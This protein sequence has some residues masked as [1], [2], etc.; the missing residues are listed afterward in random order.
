MRL[1]LAAD[2][3]E[4]ILKNLWEIAAPVL[5]VPKGLEPESSGKAPPDETAL[6]AWLRVLDRALDSPDNEG[7]HQR[8]LE[9]M[10]GLLQTLAAEDRARFL[11]EHRTLRVIGVRDARSGAGKPVSIEH[12]GQVQKA[13]CLFTFAEGFR[14]AEMGFAPLLARA[15]PNADVWLVR[16]QTYRDFLSEDEAQ[17]GGKLLPAAS[18][19]PDCLAAVGRYTGLLGDIAARHGLLEQANDPGKDAEDARRGLRF[20]LHGSRDHRDDDD[21]KLWV[22][23]HAQHPVWNRLWG[24]MHEDAQWSL[25]T[26]SSPTPSPGAVG[27]MRTSPRSTP[28][29]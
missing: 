6:A 20:L 25:L 11:T 3:P 4:P 21:A 12:L 26:G 19:G 5:L 17:R 24:V 18:D 9:A 7:A 2:L 27:V 8:I 14:G 28:G 23:R 22:G 1:A 13:G 10:Q 16:A 29:R 15:M